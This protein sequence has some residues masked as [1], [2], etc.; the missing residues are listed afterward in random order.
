[1]ANS[2]GG[3]ETFTKSYLESLAAGMV[4][5]QASGDNPEVAIAKLAEIKTQAGDSYG[6]FLI[7]SVVHHADGMGHYTNNFTGIPSTLKSIPNP[8]FHKPNADFEMAKVIDNADPDNLGRVR[9]KFIWMDDTERTAWIRTTQ[10]YGGEGG[11]N[12]GIIFTPEIGDDVIVGFERGDCDKPYV[13]HS[14]MNSK[15]LKIED[16]DNK[17]NLKKTISTR[18]SNITFHDEGGGNPMGIKINV[19]GTESKPIALIHMLDYGGK[20]LDMSAVDE[21]YI[22]TD[23][24][25]TIIQMKKDGTINVKGK[26][27]TIEASDKFHV[28]AKDILMEAQSTIKEKANS[29][30][31]IEAGSNIELKAQAN[32]TVKANAKASVES[33]GQMELKALQ[34]SV[35]ASAMLD[36]DGGGLSNLKGG[37]VMIN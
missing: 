6:K 32:F 35:K 33:S 23:N 26:N 11:T 16:R 31:T 7:T 30:V 18:N 21:V 13:A 36:L 9:V 34:I 17:D 8:Y 15:A 19:Y 1:V 37:V 4:Y 5:V 2:T 25:D 28:K 12:R 20:K 14:L 10:I 22:S 27:I 24:D 3:L 29:G